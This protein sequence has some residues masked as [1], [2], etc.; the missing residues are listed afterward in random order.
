MC[1]IPT[2]FNAEVSAKY[3]GDMHI[4]WRE[5]DPAVSEIQYEISVAKVHFISSIFV[6][7][8]CFSYTYYK[9][10]DHHTAWCT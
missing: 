2:N 8:L 10:K 1:P 5:I 7:I 3:V 6:L 9:H 4:N